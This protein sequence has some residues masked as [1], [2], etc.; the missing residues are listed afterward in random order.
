MERCVQGLRRVLIT[1]TSSGIGKA[2]ASLFLS[3]G[4]F[5]VGIDIKPPSFAHH[6][7]KH[8]QADVGKA[9]ELPD[10]KDLEIVINNAGT[11][12]EEDAIQTNLVGY[13]NVGEK[14]G[15]QQGVKAVINVGS[16]AARVGLDY[17]FYSASQGG[18][19]SY[20]RN[21]AVRLGRFNKAK[22]NSIS[23][24][25]VHSGL[26]P[27]LYENPAF[28]EQVANESILK[29]WMSVEEAAEWIY[30]VAI[31]NQSMTGQDI[32]LDNGEEA[33]C[34]FIDGGDSN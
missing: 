13:V 30:F 3:K 7:Y 12:K 24:G 9:N 22:V 14:Y 32:L 21:L 5:V 4:F 8:F 17:P 19:I 2:T 34:N 16:I 26:E 28:M 15:F 23:F 6:N 33:N 11:I 25:A 27:S 18:R 20:T 1:G 29:K 31:N 10:L